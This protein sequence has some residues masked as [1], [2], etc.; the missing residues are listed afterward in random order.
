MKI[1]VIVEAII[2]TIPEHYHA[3]TPMG[4]ME[5]DLEGDPGAFLSDCEIKIISAE[6]IK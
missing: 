2:D 4:M 6:E 3:K 5:E 1:K